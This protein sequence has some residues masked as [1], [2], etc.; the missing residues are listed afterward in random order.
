MAF[1]EPF[2]DLKDLEGLKESRLFNLE[3]RFEVEKDKILKL[4]N[5]EG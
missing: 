1:K 5:L 4:L 3:Q 2:N